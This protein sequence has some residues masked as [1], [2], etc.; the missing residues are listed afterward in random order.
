M[1]RHPFDLFRLFLS[2]FQDLPPVSRT[3]YIPGAVVLVGYPALT[4][5][6]GADHQ[7]EAFVTAFLAALALRIALG[8][9]GMLRRLLTQYSGLSAAVLALLVAGVPLTVLTLADH[10]LWCQRVQSGF[11]FVIGAVF[12]LDVLKGRTATAASFWPDETMRAYLPGLTR[13]MVVYTVAFLLQNETLIR[14]V[15]ASHWLMFWAV[16][17]IVGHMV[18]RAMVLTVI[19]LD[20]SGQPV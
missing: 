17:P 8:F 14:A 9:E 4:V 18:L 13:M 20:D 2:L 16:L 11:Y 19:N 15:E 12:L 3:L 1:H 6:L 5:L 10:P 7:A